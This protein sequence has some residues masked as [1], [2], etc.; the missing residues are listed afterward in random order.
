MKSTSQSQVKRQRLMSESSDD[1]LPMDQEFTTSGHNNSSFLSQNY[2]DMISDCKVELGGG[3]DDNAVWPSSQF[4]DLISSPSHLRRRFDDTDDDEE[5]ETDKGYD[6][7]DGGHD[8]SRVLSNVGGVDWCKLGAQ[9]SSIATSFESTF[10]KPAT[11]EQKAVYEAFQRIKLSSSLFVDG[12]N[13]MS[14]FA[15][16]VCRQVLLS[17][18][19]ILLKKVL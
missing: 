18:I 17:S 16:M 19:W 10:Y 1:E 6:D 2:P 7:V 13:S 11:A 12:E 5:E 8:D 9:L 14:G 15:K 3:N 4:P